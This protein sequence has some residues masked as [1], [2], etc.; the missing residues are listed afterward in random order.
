M[1]TLAQLRE[2]LQDGEPLEFT[3]T[4]GSM[5]ATLP[6]GS[7]VRVRAGPPR[8]GGLAF[9]D[10]GDGAAVHRIVWRRGP[11]RYQLGDAEPGGTWLPPEAILGAVVARRLPR[12]EWGREPLLARAAALL[13]AWKKL[14]RRRLAR[15]AE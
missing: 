12:G 11:L 8:L 9:Y 2:F 13:R 4:G 7:R 5:G 14:L 10:C 3:V 1:P 15:R 6:P